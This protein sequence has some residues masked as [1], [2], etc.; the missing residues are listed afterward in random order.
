MTGSNV[1]PPK[2][3]LRNSGLVAAAPR[4]LNV[5]KFIDS[6]PLPAAEPL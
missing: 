5:E 1:V 6:D 2:E 3:A 4:E